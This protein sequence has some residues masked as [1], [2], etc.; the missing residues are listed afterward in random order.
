MASIEVGEESLS[1]R[2]VDRAA[3]VSSGESAGSPGPFSVLAGFAPPAS[4]Q[5]DGRT[6]RLDLAGGG[7]SK[8]L[9]GQLPLCPAV[10]PWPP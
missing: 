1:Q 4:M 8:F 6:S 3:G 7:G 2:C 10:N 5:P 9:K